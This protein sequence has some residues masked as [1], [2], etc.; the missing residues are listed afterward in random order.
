MSERTVFS[1]PCLECG[2]MPQGG[3]DWPD[4]HVTCS[5]QACILSIIE[6]AHECWPAT[7][8]DAEKILKAH[9][10]EDE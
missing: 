5:N 7:R 4:I 8:K 1:V 6:V 3:W 9:K 2:A 10:W